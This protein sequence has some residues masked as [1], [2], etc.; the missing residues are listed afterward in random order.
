MN[1]LTVSEHQ[2]FTMFYFFKCV[3]FVIIYILAFL[4]I[5]S[6]VQFTFSVNVLITEFIIYTI[7]SVIVL[8]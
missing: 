6:V 1:K 3:E 4:N 8:K 2:I 7:Y 5:V